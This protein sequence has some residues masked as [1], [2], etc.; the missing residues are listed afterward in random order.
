MTRVTGRGSCPTIRYDSLSM[1]AE[2]PWLPKLSLYSDQPTMPLSVVTFRK[3]N[4]RQPASA[5][6]VSTAVIFMF[7]PR[8]RTR[9]SDPNTGSATRQAGE[10]DAMGK[11]DGK[12]AWVTGAGSGIG[13]AVAIAFG[14]EGA[15]VIL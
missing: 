5:R 2:R 8:S 13:E 12:V 11:L 15:R 4:I 7:P 9:G 14:R 10:E 3:E 1:T 6:R